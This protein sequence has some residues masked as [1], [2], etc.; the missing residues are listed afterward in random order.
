MILYIPY[1]NLHIATFR[2]P[3]G[4]T[5]VA[6]KP[7]SDGI[8][9]SWGQQSQKIQKDSRLS[10]SLRCT[11]GSDGK[12]Y[13]MLCIPVEKVGTWLHSISA[14]RVKESIR[15]LLEQ[16]QE[17]LSNVLY[18]HLTGQLTKERLDDFVAIIKELKSEVAD[19]RRII[20]QQQEQMAQQ[21]A[22]IEELERRERL[23]GD[24]TRSYAGSLLK[25]EGDIKRGPATVT[26][27][28][29]S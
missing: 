2:E 22:K 10:C 19:C 21:A 12:E 27:I 5:L 7:I 18:M 13:Q 1:L 9:L 8:G 4:K 24:T 16:F 25:T 11:T 23:R 3:D 6:C 28:R 29:A 17:Q 14:L 20:A 26:K 15:P